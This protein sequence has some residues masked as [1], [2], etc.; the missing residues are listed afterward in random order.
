MF[1]A[2]VYP[3]EAGSALHTLMAIQH[4][5]ILNSF[6]EAFRL[7]REDSATSILIASIDRIYICAQAH[8]E[9]EDLLDSQPANYA[10]YAHREVHQRILVHIGSICQRVEC[11]DRE[12]SLSQLRRVHESLQAH[13]FEETAE[14]A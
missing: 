13:I 14:Y 12:D 11:F 8:F 9:D 5:E 3:D 4:R 6:D 1:R 7:Y 10:S 2:A